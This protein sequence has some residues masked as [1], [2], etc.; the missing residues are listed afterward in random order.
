M[1]TEEEGGGEQKTRRCERLLNTAQ[2][3]AATIRLTAGGRGPLGFN[4]ARPYLAPG[5][6]SVTSGRLPLTRRVAASE[7][8]EA[9]LSSVTTADRRRRPR[10]RCRYPLRPRSRR[11]SSSAQT[12]PLD[13]A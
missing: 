2:L 11:R 6:R 7:G 1:T 5:D 9:G 12:A 8:E 10:C 4:S 13:V 3:P